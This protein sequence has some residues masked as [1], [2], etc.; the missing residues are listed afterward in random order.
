VTFATFVVSRA[1]ASISGVIGLLRRPFGRVL[2][3]AL[4]GGFAGL[5][6]GVNGPACVVAGTALIGVSSGLLL[7]AVASL[8]LL[9][10]RRPA[11]PSFDRPARIEGHLRVWRARPG[12]DHPQK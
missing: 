6:Y 8:V 7:G 10:R 9:R 1:G 4:T 3:L 12:P 5:L 11:R 2:S